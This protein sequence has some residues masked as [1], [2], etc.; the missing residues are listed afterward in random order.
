[1]DTTIQLHRDFKEFLRLLEANEVRYL[2]VGGY[3]VGFYGYVRPTGDLD[4]WVD[5]NEDNAVKI[6]KALGEFGFATPE[7]SSEVFTL[8]KSIVRMGI[9]PFKLEVITFIDG[10]EFAECYANR[11]RS[12]ID[13]VQV[14]VISLVDLKTNK[15][16]SGR[17]KDLNDLLELEKL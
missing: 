16:A 8:K 2:L 9:P 7:I 5:N 11:Q 3:A 17:P 13:G 14:D 10:V 6:V 1:M 15:R 4:V 12:E